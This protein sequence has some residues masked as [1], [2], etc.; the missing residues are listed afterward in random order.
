M[1]TVQLFAELT[2][3]NSIVWHN[4]RAG[5]PWQADLQVFELH[6]QKLKHLDLST[7]SNDSIKKVFWL[8]LYH[9][10]LRYLIAKLAL[11]H[12]MREKPWLFFWY[13][14]QV[15]GYSFSLNDIE[16]GILRANASAAYLPWPQFWPGDLRKEFSCDILDHRVRFALSHGAKSSPQIRTYTVEDIELQL[17]L[18]EYTF[19]K[20]NFGVDRLHKRIEASRLFSWHRSDLESLYLDAPQY[21]N[22]E[23][24]LLPFDWTIGL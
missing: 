16:H 15:G 9:I 5:I 10:L 4:Y 21:E 13:R 12:S 6:L 20:A 11:K 19:A 24:K 23:V 18:A 8:N 7:L 22:Y 2:K 3:Y 1:D 17:D 14:V